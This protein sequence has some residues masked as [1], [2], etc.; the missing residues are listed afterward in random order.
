MSSSVLPK[1]VTRKPI[2]ALI[3]IALLAL[4]VA[5]S[6]LPRYFSSWPWATPLKVANQS[7]LQA[8]RDTGLDLPGWQRV[9]QLTTKLSGNTWSI[10]ELAA[11]EGG[12]FSEVTPSTIALLL[13]PQVWEKDQPEVEWL[14]IEGAQRWQ[15][16]SWQRLRFDVTPSAKS[17]FDVDA[18]NSEDLPLTH[19]T[20]RIRTDFFRAWSKDQT[21]AVMQWYASPM[22]GSPSPAWWFW[23][24]Q[25][26]QWSARQRLPW[27]AVSLW[28][29]IDPLGDIAPYRDIA[30]VLGRSVQTEL[31][32]TVFPETIGSSDVSSVFEVLPQT[33]TSS[34]LTFSV[35]V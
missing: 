32:Q 2:T 20:I 30:T 31:M 16:D 8:L 11:T 15:T 27:V 22:G 10:Q 5:L 25:K 33:A 24:D 35:S 23:S 12:P 19:Q 7:E 4:F 9:D 13:R 17:S 14:D 3:V 21:Y 18:N 34:L 29:P 6:A 26:V 28:L 1:K